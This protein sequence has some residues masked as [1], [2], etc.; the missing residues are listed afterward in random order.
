M[1]VG[2]DVWSVA[3]MDEQR[4]LLTFALF[5]FY[6]Y[7]FLYPPLKNSLFIF[8]YFYAHP[9]PTSISTFVLFFFIFI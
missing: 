4:D 8:R 1:V 6:I 2:S 3:S 7:S 5:F 9:V